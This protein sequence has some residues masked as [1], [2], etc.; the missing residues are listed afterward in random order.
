MS[1]QLLRLNREIMSEAF[2][3]T[4]F[5]NGIWLLKEIEQYHLS[6][7]GATERRRA[8]AHFNTG[9]IGFSTTVSLALATAYF[10]PSITIEVGTFIGR[11]TSAIAHAC[12][13]SNVHDCQIHSCDH[14][15]GIDL[16]LSQFCDLT[17]YKKTSSTVMFRHLLAAEKKADMAVI[18]GRLE[19][20]DATLL[21][22]L[23]AEKSIIF[24][25]DFEGVEKGVANADLLLNHNSNTYTLI[26]PPTV[27][28]LS[29]FS[30]SGLSP[31]AALLPISMIQLVRQ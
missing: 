18:D 23:M 6:C 8:D 5:Q 1:L 9:S 4:V 10:K 12:Y 31:L 17:L 11:S 27:S 2:W 20:Q 29:K 26:Y 21:K 19:Q 30:V 22:S 14:S 24:L 3:Q 13:L 16:D 7:Y 28:L 15:N 25:D